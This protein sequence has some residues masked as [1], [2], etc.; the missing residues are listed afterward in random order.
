[1]LSDRNVHV[2][3][4]LHLRAISRWKCMGYK[5][6]ILFVPNIECA[7]LILQLLD[8][9]TICSGLKVN[10]TKTEAMWIGSC[11]QNTATPLGL[12]WSKCVKALGIVFTYNDTD[13]LQKNVYDKLKDIRIQIR[14]WNC[15]GLSLFGKVTIIKSLLLPKMLYVFSVLTTPEEFTKQLNTIIYNFLW[16]G[17]DKIARKAA[18]NDLK[19]GGLNLIQCSSDISEPKYTRNTRQPNTRIR[20]YIYANARMNIRVYAYT[21][22][23][24]MPH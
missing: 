16:K 15:R 3:V 22:Y 12:R 10:H 21:V 19:Y 8:R 4:C 14:L 6:W 17:T 2:H 18:V 13:Q 23:A 24:R 20:V 7:E 11:R 9:F 5:S 1:M